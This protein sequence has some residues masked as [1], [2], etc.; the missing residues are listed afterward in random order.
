MIYLFKLGQ[1]NLIKHMTICWVKK[2]ELK[3]Y[4]SFEVLWPWG[5]K[6]NKIQE[7]K[8]DTTQWIK[9]KKWIK[10]KNNPAIYK[11][12]IQI[13]VQYCTSSKVSV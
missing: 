12:T 4:F 7:H 11:N 10:E 1:G 3:G 8:Y 6:S 9:S 2:P 13:N 5:L